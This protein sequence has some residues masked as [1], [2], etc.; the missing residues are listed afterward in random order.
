M[1]SSYVNEQLPTTAQ[2]YIRRFDE[3]W[4]GLIGAEPQASEWI[5][6]LAEDVELD[7]PLVRFPLSSWSVRYVETRADNRDQDFEDRYFDLKV[8]EFDAGVE[9]QLMRLNQYPHLRRQWDEAPARFKQEEREHEAENLAAVLID[10]AAPAVAA[11]SVDGVALFHAS[12]P[13]AGGTTWGNLSASGST[14]L[15]VANIATEAALFLPRQADGRLLRAS[16]DTI[17][18]P[19]PL[20]LPLANLL[21]QAFIPSDGAPGAT[22]NTTTMSNP[23]FNGMRVIGNPYLTDANDWYLID[24]K[25]IA[26]GYRPLI[27]A[28]FDAGPDLGLRRFDESSDHFKSTGRVKVSSHIFKG[29]APAFGQAIR[30]VVVAP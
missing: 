8:V 4:I 27:N 13:T 23:Y 28:N 1:A 22:A 21:A 6:L 14:V 29:Y 2:D 20:A 24:S 26:R 11:N 16:P 5:D 19:M 30:K 25:L 15:N 12:H 7:T 10:N 3:R 9:E 18:V 17:M